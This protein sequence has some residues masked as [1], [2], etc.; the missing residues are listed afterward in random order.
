MLKDP[1]IFI[2]DEATSALDAK[3]ERIVHDAIDAMR[4][5]RIVLGS[6]GIRV[7]PPSAERDRGHFGFMSSE[8][9]SEKHVEH[10][11]KRLV[12]DMTTARAEGRKW[13][14]KKKSFPFDRYETV[15]EVSKLE[16]VKADDG[17]P[18]RGVGAGGPYSL[19]GN[20]LTLT[21]DYVVIGGEALGELEEI[22]LRFTIPG[23]NA[24]AVEECRIERD[25]ERLTIVFPSGNRMG[26]RRSSLP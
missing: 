24:S 4:G 20:E 3:T 25:G 6:E 22:P 11:V 7:R 18:H 19:D 26:F 10:V 13:A 2:L 12:T 8:I 15:S 5:D 9:S 1:A 17:E 21:R 14:A 23:A 16:V